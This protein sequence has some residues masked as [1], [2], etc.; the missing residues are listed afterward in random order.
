MQPLAFR[1]EYR[2]E[3]KEGITHNQ[4][5]EI[6]Q[7]ALEMAVPRDGNR[8]VHERA[9]EGPDE[10]RNRLRPASQ[11][12][13]REG[14][15]VDVGAIVGHDAEREDDEAEL[16]E[17]AERRE[18][19]RRKQTADARLR[20]AVRVGGVNGIQGRGRD[21]QAKHFREA[22]REDQACI[23]PGKGLDTGYGDGL[24]DGVVGRV[25]GP[26]GPEPEHGRGKAE[27]GACLGRTGVH[28]Q[29][30][31]FARMGELAED[32]EEDYEAGDPGPE[33]VGVDHLVAEQGDQEG[34]CR[35]DDDARIS[36]HVG[37]DRIDQLCAHDHVDRRPAH[38][39]QAIEDRNHFDAIEAEVVSR[40]HHLPK[41]EAG[42]KSAE[43]GDGGDGE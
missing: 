35:N 6:L 14:E 10:A 34:R 24:I 8:A 32:D 22:E 17:A 28:G 1:G 19:H 29:I 42:T 41:T 31:E 40:Q 7:H 30:G 16:A 15:G 3:G 9:D 27:D 5:H 43:E 12:L 23:C 38:A 21:G 33:L 18:Q 11:D 39:S 25:A 20:V 37:V 2:E 13:Q 4:Q 26:A 36:W